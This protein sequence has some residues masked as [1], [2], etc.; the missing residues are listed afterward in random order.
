[1]RDG[2]KRTLYIEGS[3][4]VQDMPKLCGKEEPQGSGRM[5][6]R[7]GETEQNEL[8]GDDCVTFDWF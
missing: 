4:K 7:T 2:A 3:R 5:S 6:R 8:C 1:M